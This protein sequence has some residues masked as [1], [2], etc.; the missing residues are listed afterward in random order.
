MTHMERITAPVDDI[1]IFMGPL[2]E[3]EYKARQRIRTCRNAAAYKL[4][5]TDSQHA[6]DLCNL[7]TETAT[8]WIYRPAPVDTLEKAVTYMFGLL[9]LTDAVEELRGLA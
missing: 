4:V 5:Q 8:Y 3:A 1:L 9:K 6:R 7:V 2:P